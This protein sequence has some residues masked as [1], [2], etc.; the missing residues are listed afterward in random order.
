MA[1]RSHAFVRVLT[2]DAGIGQKDDVRLVRP[3]RAAVAHKDQAVMALLPDCG[4]PC[5]RANLSSTQE[6]P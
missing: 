6:A 2:S 1:R 4:G 3:A 5:R